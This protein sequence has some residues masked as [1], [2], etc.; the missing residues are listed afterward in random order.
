[1]PEPA[2]TQVFLWLAVL[3]LKSVAPS[4]RIE[5]FGWADYK[6]VYDVAYVILRL[7]LPRK[8]SHTRKQDGLAIPGLAIASEARH[9]APYLRNVVATQVNLAK[10]YQS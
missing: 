3:R 1:M 8:T 7:A 6:T 9:K 5:T 10:F 4:T 2:G